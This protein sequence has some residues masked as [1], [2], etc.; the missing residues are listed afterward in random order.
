MAP[1]MNDGRYIGSI[2]LLQHFFAHPGSSYR[3][4]KDLGDCR[5]YAAVILTCITLHNVIRH[6]ATLLVCRSRQIGVAF[7]AGDGIG[8]HD[9]IAQSVDF[10]IAGLHVFIYSDAFIVPQFQP[11]VLCQFAVGSHTNGQDHHVCGK[12][13]STFQANLQTAFFTHERIHRIL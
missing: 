11:R 12:A 1:G 2:Q 13:A 6:Q 3:D 9:S 7:F 4:V 8:I 10:G 5:G